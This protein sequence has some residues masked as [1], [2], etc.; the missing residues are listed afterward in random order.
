L[1]LFFFDHVGPYGCNRRVNNWLLF[2]LCTVLPHC[3]LNNHR[4]PLSLLIFFISLC[5][6]IHLSIGTTRSISF[7]SNTPWSS[8]S[9]DQNMIVLYLRHTKKSVLRFNFTMCNFLRII[10]YP[11][12]PKKPLLSEFTLRCERLWLFPIHLPAPFFDGLHFARMLFPLSLFVSWPFAATI[13]S[14][15]APWPS[16]S[17]TV[18]SSL[19]LHSARCLL[20]SSKLL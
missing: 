6:I 9:E 19:Q 16:Y 8:K 10:S 3:V 17:S 11:N 1:L 7:L 12:N 5:A 14:T 15:D 18:I 2:A 20:P 4:R 13:S